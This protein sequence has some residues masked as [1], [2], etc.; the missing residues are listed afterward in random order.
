V[1]ASGARAGALR[2]RAESLGRVEHPALATCARVLTSADGVV[3]LVDADPGTDLAV[4]Q[5]ARGNIPP[6]EVVSLLAPVA[7][8]LAVLHGAGLVHGDVSPANIVVTERGPV[9]VDVLGAADP[10]ERG[11]PGFSAGR[12]DQP[13]G[14]GDDVVALGLVCR[15]LLGPSPQAGGDLGRR[16][17]LEAC[18]PAPGPAQTRPTARALGEA[19]RGA[20]P[21]LPLEAADPAVLARLGLRRLSGVGTGSAGVPFTVR[22]EDRSRRERARH[23]GHR[24]SGHGPASPGAQGTRRWG[25]AVRVG[26]VGVLALALAAGGVAAV[27][28]GRESAVD[29]AVRLTQE[30]AAA[31][32]AGDTDALARVTVPGS[33]AARVDAAA[34]ERSDSAA[35]GTGVG[36]GP[37]TWTIEVVA[38]G[39]VPCE[40]PSTC[41]AVRT[42]TTSDGVQRPP[43]RVVLV[44]EEG[45][46]RVA[47]VRPA[48]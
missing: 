34:A 11:T 38:E 12:S 1:H 10:D 17:L 24:R 41:V 16:E 28:L 23:R 5:E 42:I 25:T 22:A 8:A 40:E 6:G 45:P 46:W 13:A 2:A 47:E 48:E 18:T 44:L 21:A 31:L 4:L 30:R 29:A 14:P 39:L 3:V 36:D 43:R 7:D 19:M 27:A 26:G 32:L 37:G 35:G 9:L 33:A 20:C 15:A